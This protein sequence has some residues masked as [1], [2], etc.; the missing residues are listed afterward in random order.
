M[1]YHAY[2]ENFMPV[3]SAGE[4]TRHFGRYHD[5][6][7]KRP[8]TITKHGRPTVVVLSAETYEQMLH[9][10]DTRKVFRTSETPP[11]IAAI[12]LPVI[13]ELLARGDSEHG[14]DDGTVD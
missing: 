5:E 13:D 10:E 1:F 7:M 12:F 14:D 6:A 4:F 8:L 3:I 2:M 9:G 11:E